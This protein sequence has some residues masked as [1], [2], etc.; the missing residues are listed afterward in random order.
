[1]I[2]AINHIQFSSSLLNSLYEISSIPETVRLLQLS[3]SIY[4]SPIDLTGEVPAI[5]E[6]N[7]P[8]TLRLIVLKV[9][10]N[11]LSISVYKLSKSTP[12][13]H[14]ETPLVELLLEV[15]LSIGNLTLSVSLTTQEFSSILSPILIDPPALS[16]HLS[17]QEISDILATIS[18]QKNSITYSKA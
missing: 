7:L 12:D 16:S 15:A 14:H 2:G 1:M 6:V 3:N 4:H 13:I 9:A 8:I 10:L 17:I 5:R 11:H 18:H